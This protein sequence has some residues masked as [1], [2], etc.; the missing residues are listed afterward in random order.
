[1]N[2]ADVRKTHAAKIDALNRLAASLICSGA[3]A[4]AVQKLVEAE[5]DHIELMQASNE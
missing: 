3:P 5:L 1:M 2:E 4:D